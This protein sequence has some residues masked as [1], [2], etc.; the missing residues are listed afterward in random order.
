MTVR[1]KLLALVVVIFWGG[2]FLAIHVGLEHFPPL[3]LACLRWLVLAVPTVLFVRPPQR[4]RWWLFGYGLGVGTAQFAFLFLGMANGLPT[5]LASLV[6]Q[7]SAPFTVLLGAVLLR[8]RLTWRQSTGVALAVGG[9]V[10]IAAARSAVAPLLPLALGL[11]AALSWAFG[12]LCSRKAAPEDPM[13]FMLWM[14]VVPPVPLFAL[15][16]FVEGKAA[17]VT[18]LDTAFTPSGWAALAALGYVVVFA[19]VVG[20]G[21]WTILLARYPAGIVAP[22]CMLIPVVGIALAM[23]VLGERP[24]W[25][26][27]LAGMVIVA[28][29]LYGTP[30]VSPVA[31]TEQMPPMAPVTRA[32]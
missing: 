25:V 30:R 7:A 16:W 24:S 15:S 11:L 3:L 4:N 19:T 8:E 26:E 9:L 29:V 1:D 6:L 18:A 17:I 28:G 31:P 32:T 13:R 20:Q 5:G 10:A 21:I 27:L 22:Y 14:S 2:N 23:V 12:N